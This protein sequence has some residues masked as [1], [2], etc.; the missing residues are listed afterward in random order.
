MS[1]GQRRQLAESQKDKFFS[2][3]H[4]H[5]LKIIIFIVIIFMAG[6]TAIHL[7]LLVSLFFL[8]L[9]DISICATLNFESKQ[10][11]CMEVCYN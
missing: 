10:S 7:L 1:I 6:L 5:K 3:L 4:A 2:L 11:L 8:Y 9:K